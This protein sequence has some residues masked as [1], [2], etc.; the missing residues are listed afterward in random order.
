V[1]V[2]AAVLAAILGFLVRRPGEA[3]APAAAGD[4]TVAIGT[5]LVGRFAGPFELLAVL[6]VAALLGAI[7]LARTE[8]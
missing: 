5:A 2:S 6:L 4:T 7:Y 1:L 8:D 3:L